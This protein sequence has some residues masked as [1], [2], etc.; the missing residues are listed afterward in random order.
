LISVSDELGQDRPDALL[1]RV[2]ARGQQLRRRRLLERVVIVAAMLVV[3]A[4]GTTGLVLARG[5]SIARVHTV[6]PAS[7]GS[8]PSTTVPTRIIDIDPPNE[9]PGLAPLSGP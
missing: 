2:K 3:I 4:G 9:C 8:S 5:N 7:A 1:G 6:A